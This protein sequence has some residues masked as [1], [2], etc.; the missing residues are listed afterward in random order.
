MAGMLAAQSAFAGEAGALRLR[1]RRASAAPRVAAVAGFFDNFGKS[2]NEKKDAEFKKQ[3]ARGLAAQ[4]SAAQRSADT[5]AV[6]GLR[7]RGRRC[8]AR[9]ALRARH[10]ARDVCAY[11]PAG[12]GARH[13]PRVVVRR[14]APAP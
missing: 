14:R 5:P 8:H 7:C 2:S 6:A 11:V 9:P 13:A 3:Q 12:R 10:F 4:H 1:Q